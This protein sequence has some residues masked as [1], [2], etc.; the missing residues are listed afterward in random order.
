MRIGQPSSAVARGCY[1]AR[2][3]AG[4]RSAVG[5]LTPIVLSTPGLKAVINPT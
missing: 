4:R 3:P 1:Q 2:N 5:R